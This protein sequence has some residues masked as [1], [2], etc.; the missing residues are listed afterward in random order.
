MG[1]ILLIA[2]LFIYGILWSLPL[3]LCLNLV[4]WLFHISYHVTIL[5]AFGLGLLMSV[6]H[7]TLFGN[8]GV[9]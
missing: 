7:E 4:L 6:I 9:K 5:Q 3:Y 1:I 2:I 8:K